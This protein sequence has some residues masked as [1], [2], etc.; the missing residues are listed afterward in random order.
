MLFAAAL[1]SSA[2]AAVGRTAGTFNV[3]QTGAATYSIPLWAPPGPQGIEPKLALL[4][5][6]RG[7]DGSLGP[8]WSLSGLSSITRCNK[9]Y[10]QDGSPAAV[11]LT[12]S[13]AFCLDGKRLR[14]TGGTY[15]Q[16]GSTY[17]TEIADFS[18]ITAVGSA[19]NGPAYF[20]V[21]T[22][23]GHLY[24]YGNGG[25]SQVL[26]NGTTTAVAWMLNKVS[27]R[28][29]NRMQ[30]A[31]AAPGGNLVGTTVPTSISWTA[32]SAGSSSFNY[33]MQFNYVGNAPPSSIIG[34][35]AGT[36]VVDLNLLAN[37]TITNAGSGATIRKYVL[38]YDTSPTTGAFRL[39]SVKECADAAATD[40]LSPTVI[41]YQNGG[42]GIS[43]A[44]TTALTTGVSA[45]ATQYDFNAD[46]YNDL[47]YRSGS[48]TWLVAFGSSGGYGTP[49]NTGLSAGWSTM[50]FG[51]VLGTGQD[52]ILTPNG[53]TWW[54]Y[55]WNGSGFSGVSAGVA[56]ESALAGARLADVN[57]DGLA[58]LA[59]ATFFAS[60][61]NVGAHVYTR[62]NTSTGG[63]VAFSS[64]ATN[65][66]NRTT[67]MFG[68]TTGANFGVV[69]DYGAIRAP[70]FNGDGRADLLL[71]TGE[72]VVAACHPQ[73][74]CPTATIVNL[75]ISQPDGTYTASSFPLPQ[76]VG[77]STF[78]TNWNSDACTDLVVFSTLRISGCNGSP[79]S[80]IEIG[81]ISVGSLDWDS[82]GRTDLMVTDGTTLG[83]LRSVGNGLSPLITTSIPW[84][85]TIA[86]TS[87]TLDANGDGLDELGIWASGGAVTY[88]GHNGAGLPPDLATSFSDGY[89]VTHNPTYVPITWNNYVRHWDAS[90]PSR[91]YTG[92]TYVVN[93]VAASDGATGS[94]TQSFWYYGARMNLQGRGFEGFHAKYI[95]DS[96][97]QLYDI[98]YYRRD[99]P[100]TGMLVRKSLYKSDFATLIRDTVNSPN[101]IT[102]DGTPNNQRYFPHVNQIS[103]NAYEVGGPKDTQLVTSSTALLAYD[104]SG[105]LTNAATTVTDNDTT[106]PHYTQQ[107]TRT[108][109]NSFSPSAD[110]N[111]CG[112]P[113]Q[114]TVTA[115]SPGIPA[116]ARTTSYTPD[117]SMCRWTQQIVEPVSSTYK[118]TTDWGYDSFGNVSSETVTGIGMAARTTS[119]SWGATGQLPVSVTNA[120]NQTTQLGYNYNFG[121]PTSHITPNGASTQTTWSH[122][123]FGRTTS[124]TR[125]DGTYTTWLRNPT[126]AGLDPRVVHYVLQEEHAG[127]GALIRQDYL[128]K[129][130][131]DR[132]INQYHYSLT[133][134]SPYLTVTR[135]FDSLGRLAWESL[136]FQTAGGGQYTAPFVASYSY[137]VINRITQASRP[138]SASNS[139]PAIT[140]FS[141][142]GRTATVTDALGKQSTRVTTVVGTLGRSQDHDGYYQSFTYDGF[143][144][145]RSVTDSLSNT[146]F[147]A[148]YDYG[149]AAF[150]R[151]VSDI[152]GGI[153]NQSYNA[154]GEVTGASDAKNQ[155]FTFTYDPLSRPL[156]RVEPGLTTT[157][158]WGNNPALHNIGQLQSVSAGS[159]VESYAYD[160]AMRLS[161]RD[162][163]IPSD[164]S[165][166]YDYTYDAQGLLDTL[167]FPTSTAST[168]VKLKYGYAYGEL[169]SITDYTS[170][171]AGTVFW[172]AT[173][174]GPWD[175]IATE[176]F[177]NGMIRSRTFDAVTGSQSSIQAGLGGGTAIQNLSFLYDQVGN[178]TQRQD[179]SQGLT[180]NF[181]YDN[182][183]R[184]DY[185][186]LNGVTNL[187]V[188]YNALGNI[189]SKSGLGNYTYH[190]Q[191][192]H[193]LTKVASQP[194]TTQY[195][196]NG[197]NTGVLIL[198]PI[199][200]DASNRLKSASY[201]PDG[202]SSTFQYGPYG[203]RVSQVAT[204]SGVSHTISYVGD[205]LE[206]ETASGVV[207]WRHYLFGPTG[208][209]GV[210]VRKSDGTNAV[211]YFTQDPLGSIDSITNASGGLEVR[212]S[213]DAHGKRRNAAGWSG[214]V[215][216]ADY[217]KIYEITR[218]G[219]TGHEMLDHLK[220]I[221]MNGRVY[222]P[223]TGRFLSADPFVQA[224]GNTQS[225]NRYSYVLNNPLSFTD[226]SGFQ[227]GP[228]PED[229]ETIDP[230]LLI[231][232]C[233]ILCVYTF[234][235]T[236]LCAKMGACPRAVVLPRKPPE[237]THLST[238][239]TPAG[240][241]GVGAGGLSEGGGFHYTKQYLIGAVDAFLQDFWE[242]PRY[243]NIGEEHPS[244]AELHGPYQSPFSPAQTNEDQL[245]RDLGQTATVVTALITK[246]PLAARATTKVPLPTLKSS[247]FGA[248]VAD[249]IPTN[250]VPR[251]WSRTE[252]EDA[253]VDYRASIASRKAEL[254]A[255]DALG[256]GS[257]T[258]RLAHAQRITA[259]EAFLK[260]LEKALRR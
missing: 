56:V 258:Q 208:R 49:V 135:G 28:A 235:S 119:M 114:I 14:L 4:Y 178:L 99:F 173:A 247:A 211:Y 16:P 233:A 113:T 151:T 224:P 54:Y 168:R 29:N 257:A 243:D 55:A 37:V 43:S 184:L 149:I 78:L 128:F 241:R 32:S 203:Q 93:Q 250:G 148:T 222:D 186:T 65:V 147:T 139:T 228:R 226:P 74:G 30:I 8:G 73:L 199:T 36:A 11:T 130:K 102:L 189:A 143:G 205:L 12:Y 194:I 107:W 116:I 191:K 22:R 146:L 255:F 183:H 121:V 237:T 221:H 17:E 166:T 70:D 97:N 81:S 82:D 2:T 108:V 231:D 212:L 169:Q 124:E 95:H 259:E 105:N 23:G 132:A 195:D 181:Y 201:L 35:V 58:D 20:T 162:I 218:R 47:I 175:Q 125:P 157:F 18:L 57:G 200:W 207:T 100:F 219:F 123:T 160:S 159:Y 15:G 251:N 122:D 88:Y 165:Y 50:L 6:S 109:V 44:P 72:T 41:A 256:G 164:Q 152:D 85:I 213:Y 161:S 71:G 27:D 60:G 115:G 61:A 34:Y 39:T 104:S 179:N 206:K 204:F 138:T 142:A 53:A 167:T 133:G 193:A 220:T 52:G 89:G 188:S 253:I 90:Y 216:A 46:G 202:S 98:E 9:T 153:R 5:N 180:E 131:Y 48:S 33:L 25:N 129:D 51:D 229:T 112:L 185:T 236:D 64:V 210:Y 7:G 19:G 111:R 197:N 214:S 171:S 144:S 254:G 103:G 215:P 3:S 145:L 260:S 209:F 239:N 21:L 192:I 187:D 69:T 13:D 190:A 68:P 120:L 80:T 244:P 86:T 196:A 217:L 79:A 170:G 127:G 158:N 134:N 141:Y 177:G 182:L 24:E 96:R 249:A 172:Q 118:V 174:I 163:T 223:T 110:P 92:S 91:D 63:V 225:F 76:G 246:R 59:T 240:T 252:I 106:S 1:S 198:A 227:W 62:L 154:L 77:G 156:T 232:W 126:V 101:L 26:A 84:P 87:V 42:I 31:Y 40:C 245:A 248:K 83:I 75:L 234:P 242:S 67:G 238:P 38:G 117:Y 176:A 140:Q 136:P 155:N 230:G 45:L 66:Y 94:Y 150:R 10:G 137:D